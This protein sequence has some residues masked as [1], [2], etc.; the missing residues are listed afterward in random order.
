MKN[1]IIPLPAAQHR[2]G[3]IALTYVLIWAGAVFICFFSQLDKTFHYW[4]LLFNADIF[5]TG[6]SAQWFKIW[7]ESL[8]AVLTTT[9]VAGVT[10]VL[11]QRVRKVF[12][13]EFSD[14]WVRFGFDFGFGIVVLGFFWVGTGL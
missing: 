13:L 11:G 14:S 5:P 7:G 10:L 4:G 2:N 12:Q 6:D 3:F 8:K 1:T 9:L